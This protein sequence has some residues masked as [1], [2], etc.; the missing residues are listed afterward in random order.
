MARPA[1]YDKSTF[2]VLPKILRC[3]YLHINVK[4]KLFISVKLPVLLYASR[5]HN[6]CSQ[7]NGEAQLDF[8]RQFEHHEY[9]I[10]CLL[11]L[12]LIYHHSSVK[13]YLS[14]PQYV[15]PISRFVYQPFNDICQHQPQGSLNLFRNVCS[16][17]SNT[18]NFIH[19]CKN[20]YFD[21]Y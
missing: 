13:C 16:F 20:S 6:L 4:L 1:S 18:R 21:Q 19:C 10:V 7:M 15:C 5:N 11:P 3:N 14:P 17:G 2:T 8:I 9:Y 12:V